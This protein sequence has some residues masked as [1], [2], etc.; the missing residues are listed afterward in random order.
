[1]LAGDVVDRDA[2]DMPTPGLGAVVQ[3]TGQ[4]GLGAVLGAQEVYRRLHLARD[5]APRQPQVVLDHPADIGDDRLPVT[6][7]AVTV[8]VAQRVSTIV[9][10]DQILVLEEGRVVGLGTH[11]ELLDTCETYQEIVESQFLEDEAA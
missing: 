6:A 1:V 8:I 3:H 2:A 9:N 11:H 7:Q 4:V 10:A 5:E